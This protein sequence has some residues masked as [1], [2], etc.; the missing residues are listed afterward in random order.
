MKKH[1]LLQ[2]TEKD[3]STYKAALHQQWCPPHLEVARG[4]GLIRDEGAP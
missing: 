4:L 1:I 3:L 2:V